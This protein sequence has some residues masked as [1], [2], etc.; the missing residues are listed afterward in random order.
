MEGVQG[1][2]DRSAHRG[3][4]GDHWRVAC[5]NYDSIEARDK[6]SRLCLLFDDAHIFIRDPYI[7]TYGHHKIVESLNVRL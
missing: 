4:R 5:R 1:I 2:G 7:F 6:V 3:R